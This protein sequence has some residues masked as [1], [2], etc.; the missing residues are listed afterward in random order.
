[1]KPVK[2]A[3]LLLAAY[4]LCAATT[5]YALADTKAVTGAPAVLT[6]QPPAAATPPADIRDIR[7]PISI[8]YPWLFPV[9]IAG[10][11]AAAAAVAFATWRWYHRRRREGR[12]LPAH[13]RA[14]E[15]LERARLLMSLDQAYPFSC[16]VSD[17]LR[18][19][20]EQRF[21]LGATRATTEEFLRDISDNR[22]G[23]LSGFADLLRDF[24][25]YCDLAK[26]ARFMLSLE[27][28]KA[29]LDSAWQFVDKT[30][31]TEIKTTQKRRW[32]ARIAGPVQVAEPCAAETYARI[33]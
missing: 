24:L 2:T 23:E 7:G 29:L 3:A 26:F 27:Q 22:V 15:Q 20:I 18:E 8:P 12:I 14:F 16:A 30:K 21:A 9:C 6:M 11:L 28:M 33:S 13:E 10:G 25:T 1:M 31:V 32:R 5:V 17:T 19:Y 4:M